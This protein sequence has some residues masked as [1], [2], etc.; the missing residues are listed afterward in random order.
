M[1]ALPD[2]QPHMKISRPTRFSRTLLLLSLVA[3]LFTLI[4]CKKKA[5]TQ[6]PTSAVELQVKVSSP[7]RF[8]AY[9]DTRFHN[10]QDT[11]AANPPVRVA[12]VRAIADANPAFVCFTGDI[13]YNGNDADDWKTWDSETSIWREKRI[14]IFPALGNHDLHGDPTVALGNYFQR[15]PDLKNSR[16]YSVRAANALV[17]IL[18]SA[19]DETSGP[20]GQ[21]LASELDHI[22]SKVDFV[23]VMLHHPPYTSSSDEKK[24]GGGHSARSPEH[25]LAKMLEDRQAHTRARFVVFSGHVHN[26]ERHE[27]GGVTYFVTGGGAAHA[28]P[29]ERAPEDPFQSKEINYHYLLVEVDQ[30]RL[31]VTMNRLQLNNGKAVWTT[32]DQVDIGLPKAAAAA[33][34]Q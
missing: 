24:Y 32:P 25:M 11:E 15:F 12:L 1:E 9:G 34:G 16:Y 7:F 21:W 10:P 5:S 28:Y 20:Q 17:L 22:P 27:H 14:P 2:D 8:V 30:Q 18:D 3:S 6:S 29:I 13:V 23:F 33:A 19:L 4:G 26:Y 31:N